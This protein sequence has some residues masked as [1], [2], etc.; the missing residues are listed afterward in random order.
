MSSFEDDLDAGDDEEH[1]WA[2]SGDLPPSEMEPKPE[3]LFERDRCKL[4]TLV[5]P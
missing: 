4:S 5:A 1:K 3:E 2:E